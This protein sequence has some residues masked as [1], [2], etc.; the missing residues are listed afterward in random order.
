VQQ[1]L[2]LLFDE[3]NPVHRAD[4]NTVFTTEG[5][6]VFLNSTHIKPISAIRREIRRG[7]H[8]ECPEYDPWISASPIV[9][10]L[11]E[12]IQLRTDFEWARHLIVAPLRSEFQSAIELSDEPFWH[13][14]GWCEV[15][16][17]E[18]YVSLLL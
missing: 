6:L 3:D 8:N 1:Y 11:A 14:Y 16:K 13:P 5:H 9:Y 17:S 7:E 2:A 10:G 12:G 18:V 4:S 15:P